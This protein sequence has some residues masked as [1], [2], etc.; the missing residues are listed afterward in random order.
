[1][2]EGKGSRVNDDIKIPNHLAIIMDG[3]GRWAIKTGL[4]RITG[5][6]YGINILKK[7]SKIC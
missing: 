3:N 7:F 1:M 6:K 5:H 2:F 4:P